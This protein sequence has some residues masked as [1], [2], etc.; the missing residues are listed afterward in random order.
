MDT[1]VFTNRQEKL[2]DECLREFFLENERQTIEIKIL[3]DLGLGEVDIHDAIA[4]K[5]ISIFTNLNI[6]SYELSQYVCDNYG[7]YTWDY[8]EIYGFDQL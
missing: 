6:K 8:M 3:I 2:I 1:K 7:T 4:A 5:W